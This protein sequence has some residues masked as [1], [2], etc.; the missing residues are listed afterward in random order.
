MGYAAGRARLTCLPEVGD[1]L[2]AH[3]CSDPPRAAAFYEAVFGWKLGGGGAEPIFEDGTGQVIGHF[4]ADLSVA[5]EAGIRPYI[6][7]E[8][9][10]D[11][12]E[13]LAEHGGKVETA[14]Y[15]EGDV[16]VATFTDP[17]GNVLG[18]WQRGGRAT[19]VVPYLRD[20]VTC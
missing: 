13:K 12:L 1:F 7:V 2:S 10:D 16:W 20:C 6:Y 8:H 19:D 3:P 5:G 4:M 11:T 17:S 18:V 9:L 15:P 14:P